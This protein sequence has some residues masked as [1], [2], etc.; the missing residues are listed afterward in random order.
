MVLAATETRALANLWRRAISRGGVAWHFKI[1]MNRKEVAVIT[2]NVYM[3]LKPGCCAELARRRA[4]IPR[5]VARSFN[6]R[7]PSPFCS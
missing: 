5:D 7:K 3:R 2:H 1:G 4:R 6:E